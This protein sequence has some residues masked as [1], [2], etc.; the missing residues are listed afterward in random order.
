LPVRVLTTSA[1]QCL[2]SQDLFIRK[3]TDDNFKPEFTVLERR[4]SKPIRRATAR[5]RARS[6]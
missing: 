6:A 1:W 2:F 3:S 4:C 5:A